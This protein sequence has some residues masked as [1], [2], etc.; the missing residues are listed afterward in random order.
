LQPWN[1]SLGFRHFCSSLQ[2]TLF[3]LFLVQSIGGCR[4]EFTIEIHHGG[5]FVGSGH[6][7]SYIDDMVSWFDHVEADTFSPLWFP[8]FAQQLGY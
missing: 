3:G 8:D 5:F 6:L 2:G 4:E 7:K 1:K